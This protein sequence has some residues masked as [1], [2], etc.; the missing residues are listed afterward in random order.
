MADGTHSSENLPVPKRNRDGLERQITQEITAVQ[1]AQFRHQPRA[2]DPILGV[3]LDEQYG[4]FIYL[5]QCLTI[6]AHRENDHD[7]V[8]DCTAL[9][10]RVVQTCA[11]DQKMKLQKLLVRTVRD[12][13]KKLE[14]DRISTGM[15]LE[16]KRVGFF[17]RIGQVLKSLGGRN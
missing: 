3:R 8:H 16:G 12:A 5:L 13:W 17:Q 9:I 2:D 15:A 11:P 6:Q 7:W 1:E 4:Q 14:W 10:E